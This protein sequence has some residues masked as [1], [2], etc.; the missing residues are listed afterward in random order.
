MTAAEQLVVKVCL[1]LLLR[2]ECTLNLDLLGTD[3]AS[4]V[5][6]QSLQELN[7]K[8]EGGSLRSLEVL[9]SESK[10]S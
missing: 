10:E 7:I 9:G 8:W 6:D 3:P 2:N 1:I 5:L 4:L